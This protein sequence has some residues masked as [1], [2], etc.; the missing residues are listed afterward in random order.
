VDESERTHQYTAITY[1]GRQKTLF[2]GKA[3]KFR[4][5]RGCQGQA[6]EAPSDDRGRQQAG[7]CRKTRF[8]ITIHPGLGFARSQPSKRPFP[9]TLA[10]ILHPDRHAKISEG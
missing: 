2:F 8:S 10:I 6:I 1:L 9:V 4:A 7:Y 3:T 5:N